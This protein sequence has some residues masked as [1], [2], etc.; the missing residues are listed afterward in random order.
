MG[1]AAADISGGSLKEKWEKIIVA[2]DLLDQLE[3][4]AR[5]AWQPQV[6]LLG[7]HTYKL[8]SFKSS[9]PG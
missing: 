5:F 7:A 4:E 9:S 3:K 2:G 6:N 1:V 8:D